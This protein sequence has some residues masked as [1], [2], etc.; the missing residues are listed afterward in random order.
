MPMPSSLSKAGQ[1]STRRMSPPS[2]LRT[3]VRSR[4]PMPSSL[5]GPSRMPMP[6]SLPAEPM[7]LRMRMSSSLQDSKP[8]SS[9]D[10]NDL[11]DIY[12]QTANDLDVCLDCYKRMSDGARRAL[13]NM[14]PHSFQSRGFRPHEVTC[15]FCARKGHEFSAPWK[16]LEED[17][18]L[19]RHK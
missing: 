10:S 12:S 18:P 19:G 14:E 3:E 16:P 7:L 11:P 1:G 17:P 5:P 6:S 13:G 2:S 9:F 4:M 15:D 8:D